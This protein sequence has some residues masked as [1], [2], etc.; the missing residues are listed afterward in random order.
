MRHA[1][2]AAS[3]LVP[4]EPRRQRLERRTTRS[5]SGP[6]QDALKRRAH[7]GPGA[8]PLAGPERREH[9]RPQPSQ[10]RLPRPS[11]PLILLW[12]AVLLSS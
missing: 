2:R 11:V 8:L 10:G 6:S 12:N 9:R 7:Q 3:D 5:D 4:A 1:Q